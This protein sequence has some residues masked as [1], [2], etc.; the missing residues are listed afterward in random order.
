MPLNPFFLQ[1]SQGEQRLIQDLINEQVQ[2]Y[3]IEVTYIPRKFVNKQSIIEEI[4]SS[5]FEDN[6]LLEAYVNTYEGYSGAGDV[7][8]KFGVSLRDELTV[9]ISK[10]RFEDFIAPFLDDLDFELGSRP[11]EGDLIYFPLGQRLF[12]VK[13]VEHEKPFYQLQKNYVYELQCELFEYEDEIIDTSID[14]IDTQ[15]QDE[16]FITT[17]EL[18]GSGTTALASAVIAPSITPT[19]YIRSLTVLNDGTGYSSTPTVFISTSRHVQGVN[20]S[21]VAITTSVDGVHSIKELL[22]TNAGAGYTQ[23]PNIHIVGGG[24]SGA[25]ATCTIEKT[26]KG[27]I[28]FAVTGDGAGY[29][30]PPTVTIAGPTGSGTTAI[31]VPVV[32]VSNGQLQSIRIKDPGQG[33]TSSPTVTI[34]PPDIITGRGNF[35][36]NDI[37]T[38]Q[39]SGTQAR[40]KEWDSDTKILKVSNVGIGTTTKGF[41]PGEEVHSTTVIYVPS[42]TVSAQNAP[43][44]VNS[45]RFVGVETS[46]I[47]IGQDISPVDGVISVGTTVLALEPPV[48][49]ALFGNILMSRASLNTSE[50]V[51][52]NVSTGS[53]QLVVYNVKAHDTRDIYDSYSDNDEFE[54]EADA[55]ID[56]AESN[57]FGT[58]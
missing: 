7:M 39:T 51:T 20:A 17:L 3:G 18:V 56:F 40:V 54:T 16:G 57:P 45:T 27:V 1:G 34:G 31:G 37:V 9:T 52:I 53:T 48:A 8:T 10:E 5:R 32:D 22:L 19:G 55:I 29:V 49:P 36:L 44:G 14:E 28:Q 26:E 35:L 46:G 50:S 13:F 38:G 58:F 30:T 47:V 11:R 23:A 41:L 42:P 43:I 2:I 21:A 4:Q 25:I 12:E 6:F 33:Y 15:V 24:G